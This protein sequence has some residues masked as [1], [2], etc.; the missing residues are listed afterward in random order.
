MLAPSYLLASANALF[1]KECR[2]KQTAARNAGFSSRFFSSPASAEP[3]SNTKKSSNPQAEM[4]H[5]DAIQKEFG[6]IATSRRV[7]HWKGNWKFLG[8]IAVLFGGI[9]YYSIWKVGQDD[10]SDV[11]AQG[12]FREKV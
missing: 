3:E 12:N 10:F 1:G 6:T 5:R 4:L 11:D 8:A 7:S 2:S 9:Y